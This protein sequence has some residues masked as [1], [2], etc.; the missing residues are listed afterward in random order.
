MGD[1]PTMGAAGATPRQLAL[2]SDGTVRSASANA[3][4]KGASA[5]VRL[6]FHTYDIIQ[7]AVEVG[8]RHGWRRA[9]KHT[10]RPSMEGAM[11][12]IVHEMML[13]LDAVIDW[14]E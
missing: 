13:A 11:D 9:H 14:K 5:K 8:A 6:K 1:I 7:E 4:K 12:T 2:V 10:D 3:M